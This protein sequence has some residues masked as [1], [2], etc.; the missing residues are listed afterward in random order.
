MEKCSRLF[1]ITLKHMKCVLMIIK[2]NNSYNISEICVE[3]LSSNK[4]NQINYKTIEIKKL[5]NILEEQKNLIEIIKN[6]LLF[7]N[8]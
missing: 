7:I 1:K 5:S 3:I 2:I 4:K 8:Y 6:Y